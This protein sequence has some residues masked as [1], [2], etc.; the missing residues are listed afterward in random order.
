MTETLPVTTGAPALSLSDCRMSEPLERL[1]LE[2]GDRREA[3]EVIASHP[4]LREE[5]RATLPMLER[6]LAPAGPDVVRRALGPL[7]LVFGVGE[8][9]K[10]AVWWKVYFD[11]L[12]GLPAH[13][14]MAAAEAY[15]SEPGAEWFPKP[16]VLKAIVLKFAGPSYQAVGRARA[17]VKMRAAA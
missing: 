13:A 5:V 14:V 6:T 15:P 17:A 4:H 8:Q 11:A 10:S 1:L 2:L 7:V 9:A 16:A 3:L 12:A